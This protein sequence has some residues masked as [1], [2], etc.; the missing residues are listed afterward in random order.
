MLVDAHGLFTETHG[1]FFNTHGDFFKT[2]GV[3]SETRGASSF[4][5]QR[6]NIGI[7][8]HEYFAYYFLSSCII[9][10]DVSCVSLVKSVIKR[11]GTRKL[12]IINI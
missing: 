6:Y 12:L 10:G 2:H 3:F 7:A 5:L 8:V 11:S 4:R 1:V 9:G